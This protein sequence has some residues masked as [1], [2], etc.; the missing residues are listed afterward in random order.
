MKVSEGL[1]FANDNGR[2]VFITGIPYPA[3]NDPRVIHKM[4]YLDESNTTKKQVI[5]LSLLV[6]TFF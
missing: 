2:A 3:K 4:K 5:E 1:D 6:F